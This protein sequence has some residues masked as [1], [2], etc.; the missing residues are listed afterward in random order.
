MTTTLGSQLKARRL[1]C[2]LS[3]R[4]LAKAAGLKEDHYRNIENGKVDFPRAATL[5]RITGVLG[6][7]VTVVLV[8]E[9]S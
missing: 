1:A 8:E 9:A 4:S 3:Q 7:T 5:A 2:G 6:V